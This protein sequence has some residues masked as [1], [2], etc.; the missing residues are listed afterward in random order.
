MFADN[1]QISG[2]QLFCQM[3]LGISGAA[4]LFLPGNGRL[5]GIPGSLACVIALA[6][7]LLYCI[8]L[9]RIGPVYSH[10]EKNIGPF[11]TKATG[12]LFLGYFLLTGAFLVD[13]IWE[14][15]SG[16]MIADTSKMLIHIAV[17]L[18]C[19]MAGIPQIQRRGRLAEFVFPFFV[20]VLVL[21]IVLAFSQNRGD[22][23]EYLMQGAADTS[24]AEPS[25]INPSAADVHAEKSQGNA[26]PLYIDVDTLVKD[27]YT[28][29]TSFAC[30]GAVPF[31][32]GNVKSHRYGSLT[33]GIFLIF[34]FLIGMLL[35]VQGSYGSLQVEN[36]QWPALSVMA[37][38]RIPGGFVSRMDPIWI[39]LMLL[40]LLFS[41]GSTFFY[42]NFIVKKTGLGVPWYVLYGLVYVFSLTQW[43]G[44]GIGDVYK[45]ALGYFFAPAIFLWNVVLGIKCRRQKLCEKKES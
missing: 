11:W 22:L 27:A 23:G 21:M 44:K 36:R 4:I 45:D 2:R 39:S 34:S 15:L 42:G 25:M 31:L 32:L 33:A 37:G 19:A 5:K 41:V 29:L 3:V 16:Y 26:M 6:V 30:I 14:I 35:L 8:L 9:V 17:V 10:L 43:Q 28:I 38:I 12:L 18:A 13:L 7:L 40:F 20:G 24:I 1:N